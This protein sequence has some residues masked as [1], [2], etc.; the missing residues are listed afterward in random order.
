MNR[1]V[2]LGL[3][4][5]SLGALALRAP[6]LALRPMHNDEAV[7]AAKIRDLWQSGQYAYDPNEHHGPT[8]YY[9][10]LPLVFLSGAPDYDHLTEVP[11]RAVS[12]LFGLALILCLWPLS[13]GLSRTGTLTA[14]GLTALSPAMVFYS[15]YF[16]H[17]MLLVCFALLAIAAGWRYLKRPS[18]VWAAAG[19]A[20]VGL[21]AATKETFVL[22]LAA[23][24]GALVLAAAWNRWRRAVPAINRLPWKRWHILLG[25]GVAALVAVIFFTSFFTH[26][27]GPIDALRTYVPWLKR[28]GGDSPHIHPWSFYLERIAFFKEGKGPAWSEGL[29]LLLALL[30][31]I[32][33]LSNRAS[34]ADHGLARF[35]TFY[36]ILLTAAYSLIAY[37]TPWC[38]LG[39]LHGMILLAGIGMAVALRS[40]RSRAGQAVLSLALLGAAAHLGWQAW[41]ASYVF[42]ADR[43]NPYVYA[44]TV[45]DILRLVAEVQEIAKT[46]P[47]P[48]QMLIKVMAPEADYWPLP[49]YLRQFKRVG[50]WDRVPSDPYAPVMIVGAGLHAAFDDKSDKAWPMVGLFELRPKTFLE[51]YVKSELWE[52]Y[53]QARPRPKDE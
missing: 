3:L 44:Q 15:R 24:A 42:P 14:A 17:E 26:L 36:T 1:W 4:L 41:R 50:W 23:G 35:L 34:P 37:K 27:S 5:I 52:R 45:P 9:A 47:D 6:Q 18:A 7:N 51:L 25:S 46:D 29:I 2:A 39:F 19:G 8:L 32:A 43:R 13:D 16:I 12:V 22:V 53:I 20:S 31:A 30:G 28:A 38:L 48:S 33:S 21:M 49:W 11:L 10:T 40:I